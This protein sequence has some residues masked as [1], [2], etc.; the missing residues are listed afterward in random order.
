MQITI[1]Q[2][3]FKTDFIAIKLIRETV[4]VQEQNIPAEMEWD[5]FDLQA[6]HILAQVQGQAIG[7]ARLLNDGSIGRVAVL[8][9]WRKQGVGYK[10]MRYLM[11]IAKQQHHSKIHLHAQIDALDFYQKLGFV[12]TGNTFYEAGI[13][14]QTTIYHF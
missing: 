11:D 3:D 8:K 13:L 9:A 5:Q 7:T 14:H 2:A 4:F 12:A 6:I 10:M 1:Y